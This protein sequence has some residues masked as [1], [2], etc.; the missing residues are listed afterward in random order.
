MAPI[1][2]IVRGRTIELDSEIGLPDGQP[3]TVAVLP[4]NF[5]RPTASLQGAFG[6]WAD[7]GESIDQFL[8]WN[9]RQR[10]VGG[11]EIEPCTRNPD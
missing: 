5:T 6:A 2:G 1:R 7:D 9:R 10:H 4:T 11:S 8:A 3:V